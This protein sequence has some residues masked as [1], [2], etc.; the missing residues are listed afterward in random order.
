MREA[1][2]AITVTTVDP[3]RTVVFSSTQLAG[4]QGNGETDEG[5][6][7]GWLEGAF[8][9]VLNGTGNSVQVTRSSANAA[10]SVTFYVAELLP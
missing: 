7:T 1:T 4:G 2:R 6:T 9:L 5:S 8:H 10:A 3:T